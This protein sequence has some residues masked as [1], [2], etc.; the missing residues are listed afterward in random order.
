MRCCL[1]TLIQNFKLWNLVFGHINWSEIPPSFWCRKLNS[2]RRSFVSRSVNCI[3]CLNCKNEIL[4]VDFDLQPPVFWTNIDVFGSFLV[5]YLGPGGLRKGPYTTIR[6][7]LYNIWF[8]NDPQP[9]RVNFLCKVKLLAPMLAPPG[10]PWRRRRHNS[11]NLA[12]SAETSSR[13]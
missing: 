10:L 9:W 2:K 8:R 4:F 5:N 13:S 6:R 3:E 7:A 12:G 11:G 1:W